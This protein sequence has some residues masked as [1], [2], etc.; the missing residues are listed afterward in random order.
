MDA[1]EAAPVLFQVGRQVVFHPD[2]P[3]FSPPAITDK[4]VWTAL[5]ARVGTALTSHVLTY[6][7]V[8][9]TVAPEAIGS[10]KKNQSM[11]DKQM[12]Q[13]RHPD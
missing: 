4:E 7:A 9:D 3:A 2:Y 12:L 10:S 5:L 11:H 6:T 1:T 13:P 8:L